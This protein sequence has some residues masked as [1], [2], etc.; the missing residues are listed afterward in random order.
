MQGQTVL[1]ILWRIFIT[2]LNNGIKQ[3]YAL[4]WD[5][6]SSKMVIFPSRVKFFEDSQ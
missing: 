4:G 5:H 1:L 3:I 2:A 6:L